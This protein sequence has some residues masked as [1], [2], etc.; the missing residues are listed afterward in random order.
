MLSSRAIFTAVEPHEGS[1]K[2]ILRPDVWDTH[3]GRGFKSHGMYLQLYPAH[4]FADLRGAEIWAMC[5]R[6]HVNHRDDHTTAN[7]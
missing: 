1:L 2:N 4:A 5:M 6:T 7:L 3:C